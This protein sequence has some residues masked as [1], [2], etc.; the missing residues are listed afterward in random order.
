MLFVLA[1]IV[2]VAVVVLLKATVK[3]EVEPKADVFSTLLLFSLAIVAVV[4]INIPAEP[5]VV[6]V[7]AEPI[8]MVL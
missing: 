6:V 8:L 4:L 3:P 2:V 1:S 5:N 7:F